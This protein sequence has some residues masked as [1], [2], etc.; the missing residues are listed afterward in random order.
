MIPTQNN[1]EKK[2]SPAGSWSWSVVLVRS[3]SFL[4]CLLFLVQSPINMSI[5]TCT[6][7][8]TTATYLDYITLRS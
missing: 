1:E 2:E 7:H 6:V 8:Y 5:F 4:F 3:P